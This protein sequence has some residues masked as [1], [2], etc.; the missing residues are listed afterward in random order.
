MAQHDY[1][2][3]NQGFPAF[4]SDLNDALA[5]VV[6]NNSGAT[7]PTTMFAH[8]MWVDTAANPSILKIRNADND[9]WITIGSIDQT[10]DRFI[11][12]PAG[13][14]AAAPSVSASGDLDTGLFFPGS[15]V[16]GFA[17]NG[18]E[19]AR[20]NASGNLAFPNG[21]GIDFSAS[22]GG[23]ATSSIL[24]DYEEG[25]FTPN[26]A[27]GFSS[28]PTGYTRQTGSYT[29]IGRY[30]YFQIDLDPDGATANAN[31]VVIGGLPFTS[32]NSST[33]G[34]GGANISYQQTF[35]TNASDSYHITLNS[36]GIVV[37]DANGVGRA[38]NATGVNINTRIILF[39]C[40]QTS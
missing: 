28:A 9:A 2:I 6:S 36:T 10:G 32:L 30:V 33:D 11:F 4:R 21:N 20:F 17:T 37:Y 22:A 3:A 18:A 14:S 35:N 27:D 34:F 5:A 15:N 26:L 31:A 16:L 40:Y 25:T 29:K 1:T 39:G 24:D 7:E 23:G 38:G 8:Q 12:A 13:G 19:A